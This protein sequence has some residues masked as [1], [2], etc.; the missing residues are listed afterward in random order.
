MRHLAYAVSIALLLAVPTIAQAPDPQFLITPGVGIGP[1]KIG[2]HI[3]DAARILGTPR[4]VPV[5]HVP[6]TPDDP[7][8]YRWNGDF[9]AETDSKGVIHYLWTSD[10]R[11]ATL[12]GLRAG[13]DEAE[14]RP[15]LGEPSRVVRRAGT[16]F[17]YD[18]A[19]IQFYIQTKTHIVIEI[20]VFAPRP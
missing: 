7:R 10:S 13:S 1:L 15:R 4:L 19:G 9:A 3:D 8:L 12:E 11:Y 20:A 5:F 18:Y 14:V 6:P 2:M 16:I 17:S